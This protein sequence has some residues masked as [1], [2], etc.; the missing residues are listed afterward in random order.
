MP[1]QCPYCGR[2]F[3]NTKA[4]GSHVAYIHQA[5]GW[6]YAEQKRTDS[7]KERFQQLLDGCLTDRDLRRP[8]QLDKIELA[9]TEIPEGISPTLDKVREAYKCAIV[10]EQLVKEVE[11]MVQ[12][13][14]GNTTDAE[15]KGG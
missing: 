13:N 12:D 10:K 14:P 11:E 7:E 5:E 4:L 2:S 1:E 15:E 6:A 9:F 3:I 8:R